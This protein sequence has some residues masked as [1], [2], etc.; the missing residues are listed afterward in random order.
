MQYDGGD[1]LYSTPSP[2]LKISGSGTVSQYSIVTYVRRYF[3]HIKKSARDIPP[4]CV[5]TVWSHR[6]YI[7]MRIVRHPSTT[8]KVTES[9]KI[10][11]IQ[12][13]P[14][15]H[16]TKAYSFVTVDA[17]YIASKR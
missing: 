14:N 15:A 5:S 7:I 2:P 16:H 8:S 1:T 13:S 11:F 3:P 12:P 6:A 17:S 10:Q 4:K 9:R